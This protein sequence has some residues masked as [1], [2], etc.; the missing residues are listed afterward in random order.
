MQ[1]Y[2][3]P[4]LQPLMEPRVHIFKCVSIKVRCAYTFAEIPATPQVART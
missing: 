2:I 3:E 1:P 4:V